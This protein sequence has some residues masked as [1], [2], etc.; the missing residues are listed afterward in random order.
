MAQMK[1]KWAS[2]AVHNPAPAA[3]SAAENE[4]VPS[5]RT[6]RKTLLAKIRSGDSFGWEEFYDTYKSFIWSVALHLKVTR[7]FRLSDADIADLIQNVMF[8]FCKPGKFNYDPAAG[9]KF[10]TWLSRVV[11]NKLLDLVRKKTRNRPA[12]VSERSQDGDPDR[13]FDDIVEAEW[14]NFLFSEAMKRLKSEVQPATFK[15]FEMLMEGQSPHDVG[16]KLGIRENNVYQ[17]KC[18][19]ASRLEQV[20]KELPDAD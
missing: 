6:T 4:A 10:R 20:W 11:R 13:P 5:G 7:N 15:A 12:D 19:C 2:A 14:R 18:R 1:V 8:D 3:G 16:M 9:V 17:I